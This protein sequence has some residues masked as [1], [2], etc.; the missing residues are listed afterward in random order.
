M[1]TKFQETLL[2]LGR[3]DIE[4]AQRL[5]VSLRSITRY[6]QY[7]APELPEPLSRLMRVPELLEALA[8]DARALSEESDQN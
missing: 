4:R 1:L 6:K 2:S 5:G 8:N 7:T 3:N